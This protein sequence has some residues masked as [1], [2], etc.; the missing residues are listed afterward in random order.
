MLSI[1]PSTPNWPPRPTCPPAY[2]MGVGLET[3]ASPVTVVASRVVT[4]PCTVCDQAGAAASAA[5][6]SA[7]CSARVRGLRAA[8]RGVDRENGAAGMEGWMRIGNK[9]LS[10]Y[11][12]R[13]RGTQSFSVP[14]RSEERRVGKE[15]R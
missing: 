12:G 13:D 8:G 10:Y 6:D 1:L 2:S 11:P 14:A 9:N 4:E 7:A 15:C 3:L 5:A